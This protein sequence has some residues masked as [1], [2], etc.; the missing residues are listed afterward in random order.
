MENLNLTE[1][2]DSKKLKNYIRELNR[3]SLFLSKTYSKKYEE[4]LD[5]S[6]NNTQ[7]DLKNKLKNYDDFFGTKPEKGLIT[8]LNEFNFKFNEALNKRQFKDLISFNVF[9]KEGDFNKVLFYT[10]LH[11]SFL[12]FLKLSIYVLYNLNISKKDAGELDTFFRSI[13]KYRRPL[14]RLEAITRKNISTTNVKL[15]DEEFEKLMGIKQQGLINFVREELQSNLNLKKYFELLAEMQ[16]DVNDRLNPMD[17]EEEESKEN[18]QDEKKIMADVKEKINKNKNTNVN[19]RETIK[20][21][22]EV[23]RELKIPEDKIN[24]IVIRFVSENTQNIVDSLFL[25]ENLPTI[26]WRKNPRMGLNKIVLTCKKGEYKKSINRNITISGKKIKDVIC[27]PKSSKPAKDRMKDRKSSLKRWKT[28]R[29]K[30]AQMRRIQFKKNE[31]K[32][33]SKTIRKE[34]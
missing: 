34:K 28:L 2:L 30:P 24:N 29:S 8:I 16:N 31:T 13:L 15:V 4:Y 17:D 32:K 26:R 21:F 10:K 18:K 27:L 22:V 6:L 33:Y 14:K 25:T 5:Y 12:N 11:N 9:K 19:Y 20:K 23:L 7:L 1:D 3:L